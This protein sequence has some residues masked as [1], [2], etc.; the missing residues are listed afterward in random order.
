MLMFTVFKIKNNEDKIIFLSQ[1]IPL[2]FLNSTCRV[3]LHDM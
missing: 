3:F 2:S 1:D